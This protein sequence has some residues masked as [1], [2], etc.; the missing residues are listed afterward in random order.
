MS[1]GRTRRYEPGERGIDISGQPPKALDLTEASKMDCLI[2]VCSSVDE[3]CPVPPPHV[4][5]LDWPLGDPAAARGTPD[6]VL[7]VFRRVRDEV[8]PRVLNLIEMLT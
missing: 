7:I 5:R 3:R 6:E 2:T 4:S 1:A 8:E